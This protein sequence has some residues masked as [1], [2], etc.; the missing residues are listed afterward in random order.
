MSAPIGPGD[1]VEYYRRS[2]DALYKTSAITLG[3]LYRVESLHTCRGRGGKVSQSARFVGIDHRSPT[4][5]SGFW[6]VNVWCLRPI[7]RPSESLF[8]ERL[9]DVP[10]SPELEPA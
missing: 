3:S 4:S 10:A 6:S 8:L 9:M 7:Y 2:N 5:K 1:W